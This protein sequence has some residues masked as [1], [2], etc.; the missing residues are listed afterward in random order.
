MDAYCLGRTFAHDEDHGPSGLIVDTF[1]QSLIY[2]FQN[3]QNLVVQNT[4]VPHL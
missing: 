4:N 1:N 2:I 3:Q